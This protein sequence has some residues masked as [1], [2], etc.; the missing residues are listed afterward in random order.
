MLPKIEAPTYTITLPVSKTKLTFRPFLVKEQ[1]ILLMAMESQD[2]ETAQTNVR[3]VLQNCTVSEVDIDSLPMVDVEYYFLNLRAKSIGEIVETKYKCENT[4]DDKVCNNTLDVKFNALD[5]DITI[6]ENDEVIKLTDH[7]GVKMRYPNFSVI[8]KMKNTDSLTDVAFELTRECIEYVYDDDA[9]YYSHE[10]P[11]Q[12]L[13]DFLESLTKEQ[14]EKIESFVDNLPSIQ[15][16]ID[17]KCSKCGFD[18]KIV[19]KDLNSF[20]Q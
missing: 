16:T 1:K 15:K 7:I 14:F 10:T 5:V 17:V 9:F 18:H 11:K 4:V 6:P 2:E 20:F 3:Q 8:E 12:E 13:N 19:L